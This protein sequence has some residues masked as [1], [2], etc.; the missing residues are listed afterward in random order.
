[1]TAPVVSPP[2]VADD[3]SL[4]EK[5]VADLVLLPVE[6]RAAALEARL[7]EMSPTEA[8]F[9]LSWEGRRRPSQIIDPVNDAALVLLLGGKG[10][11]KTRGGSEGMCDR[12]EADQLR[13]G[14]FI[15]RTPGDVRRVMIEGEESGFMVCAERRGIEAHYE[16]S[17]AQISITD[18]GT[19]TLYSAEV[20]DSLRGPQHDTIWC[21]PAGTM[22]ST[23]GGDV[24][25]ECV[26][27]GDVVLTRDGT[28]VVEWAGLTRRDAALV[29]V[30]H[31][32]GR[33]RCTPDHP[34]WTEE[35]GWLRIDETRPGLTLWGCD[36]HPWSGHAKDAAGS[37]WHPSHGSNEAA[38]AGARETAATARSTTSNGT[39]N[40]GT[41]KRNPDTEPTALATSCT[42]PSGNPST[43]RSRPATPSRSTTRIMTGSTTTSRTLSLSRRANTPTS[44][45]LEVG[46]RGTP[47]GVGATGNASGRSDN[48]KTSSVACAE[49]PSNRPGCAPNTAPRIAGE[50]YGRPLKLLA[51]T[52]LAETADTY[53]LTIRGR[54]EFFADGVL[55][56]NCDEFAAWSQ[57]KDEMGNTTFSNAMAGLRLG[58]HPLGIFTTTPKALPA[59][60]DIL[61]DET[62]LWRVARMTTWGNAAN[63]PAVYLQNLRKMYGGTRLEAQEFYGLYVEDVEGA[64]WT[65]EGLEATRLHLEHGQTWRDRLDE[66]LPWRVIGVDPSVAKDGGGD[67][68]GIVGVGVGLDR[69]L[70]AILDA[71]GHLGPRDWADRAV[72]AYHELGASCI[73]AEGNQGGALVSTVIANIDATIPVE[74][75]HAR[76]AKRAR[77]EPISMLWQAEEGVQ[78]IGSIVG[79]LP[80]LEAELTGWSGLSTESPNR[81]DAFVW[82]ASRCLPWLYEPTASW[83][84]ASGA[85]RLPV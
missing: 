9:M 48:R 4:A 55:V 23:L 75:V 74:I 60:K 2:L 81:L 40:A 76:A 42:E 83:S 59:I 71:S 7:A 68:C 5:L 13:H 26:A 52:P 51:V 85:R 8:A 67:E 16:P 33:F 54:P 20:P 66:R 14:A 72:W 6:E 58:N 1:V 24:P 17:K 47:S 78:P 3:R 49:S 34:V 12:I 35:H 84:S 73:V 70:Y 31:S 63:L 38:A 80:E 82:A 39:A 25:I 44:T 53:D 30:E 62:G 22:V 36:T 69:R 79:T 32:A 15:S 57:K 11:G 43:D 45:L 19:I 50:R 56:H 29:E 21:L 61:T 28:G 77:A 64:L 18:G 65:T 27:A 46:P 37:S 10:G 41:S